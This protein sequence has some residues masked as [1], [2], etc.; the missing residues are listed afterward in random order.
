MYPANVW[1]VFGVQ[2]APP[3][4]I[5]VFDGAFGENAGAKGAIS[6]TWL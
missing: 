6:T 2:V 1:P 3:E 5:G 4:Q